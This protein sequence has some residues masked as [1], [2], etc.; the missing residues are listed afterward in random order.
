V[1]TR[2][3]DNKMNIENKNHWI[4]KDNKLIATVPIPNLEDAQNVI[5]KYESF[6]QQW[7]TLLHPAILDIDE[8][9]INTKELDSKPILELTIFSKKLSQ[10]E[11]SK[12]I[13]LSF[14]NIEKLFIIKQT[15][16]LEIYAQQNGLNLSWEMSNLYLHPSGFCGW[17][18]P[19][20]TIKK[21]NEGIIPFLFEIFD[22][23]ELDN[24][25]DLEKEGKIPWEWVA[26]IESY[27][28]DDDLDTLK[29]FSFIFYQ[30]WLYTTANRLGMK[31]KV[32]NKKDYD[33]LYQFGISLGLDDEKIQKINII[34]QQQQ[35]DYKELIAIIASN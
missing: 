3:N 29:T 31:D 34:A 13:I 15:L 11:P 1:G 6:L 10:F 35:P 22:F 5:K 23:G 28:A 8:T 19:L 9:Q 2:T 25:R 4:Q 30:S 21:N 12:N 7:Q 16:S 20:A 26:F 18:P 32:L 14:S 24:W 27:L 33:I 17:L